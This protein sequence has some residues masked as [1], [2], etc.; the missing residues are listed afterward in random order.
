MKNSLRQ[1]NSF[2]K[3][4]QV[5]KQELEVWNSTFIDS[6][7]VVDKLRQDYINLLIPHVKKLF[8]RLT[9]L[10]DLKLVYYNGWSRHL[11]LSEAIN[12]DLNRDILLGYTHSGP[13]RADIQITYK[14]APVTDILS[15]GQQK[16]VIYA[17][18][19]AQSL[20]FE[21]SKKRACIFLLDD[22]V[23]ELDK[24][25]CK[26]LSELLFEIHSQLWITGI[27]RS[28][29]EQVFTGN[30]SQMFHVEHGQVKA[31]S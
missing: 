10:T 16:M 8:A 9:D 3:K 2:L 18:K 1:R 31:I 21:E 11:S 13:Q 30:T 17:I 24:K 14:G 22:M 23:S 4:K 6:A 25:H 28:A 20:I 5:H 19:L 27:K 12:K 15:R 26:A 7:L 29:L